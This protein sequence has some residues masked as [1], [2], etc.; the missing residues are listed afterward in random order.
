[1][2]FE[3]EHMGNMVHRTELLVTPMALAL[4][5]PLDRDASG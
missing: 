5:S 1:V 2:R 3:G 4:G